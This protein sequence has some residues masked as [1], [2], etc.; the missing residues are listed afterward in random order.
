MLTKLK[1]AL[2]FAPKVE[3]LNFEDGLL[4]V[5]SKKALSFDRTSVKM[6]TS[7]GTV[8]ARVLVESYDPTNEVYRMKVADRQSMPV[9]LE[10]ERREGQRLNK[11]LRVTSQAFPQFAGTTEDISI[12]GLRVTTRGS[13]E[14]GTEIVVTLELDDH[15]IPSLK[16]RA[17]VA[18][19]ALKPDGSYQS[20][21]RFTALD[22]ET[23][24]LIGHYIKTRL[25]TEKR[26]H[27]TEE[28]DPF[29]LM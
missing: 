12:S 15:R 25:A 13:L 2:T 1:N 22:G 5:R 19:S 4:T 23:E 17:L 20:G 11:V 29:E 9:S 18:W 6:T 24:R 3:Y 14:Q 21:L 27:T 7:N 8:M 16:M 10:L 28:V 26:L